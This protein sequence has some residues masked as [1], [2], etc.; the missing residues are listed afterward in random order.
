M[1]QIEAFVKGSSIDIDVIFTDLPGTVN[2]P[3]VLSILAS[4][5]HIFSPIT[6]DRVVLESTLSF[7]DI[8]M[9][10]I[11]KAGDTH[12]KSLHLFWNQVDGR[13]KSPLYEVYEKAIGELGLTLM[14]TH[15]A[16]S[17]RF[18]KEGETTAKAVFRSTL[19]PPDEQLMKACRLDAFMSEFLSIIKL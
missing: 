17:K 18:R 3:G 1:D 16:D 15:I 11:V 7:S 10:R 5:H 13:E 2:T 14:Q 12:I 6:A 8:L 19:L 4:S 9:N